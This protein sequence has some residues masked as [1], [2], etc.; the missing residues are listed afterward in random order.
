MVHP[1]APLPGRGRQVSARLPSCKGRDDAPIA[2]KR[3]RSDVMLA[4]SRDDHRPTPPGAFRRRGAGTLVQERTTNTKEG[5]SV[6][7]LRRL[8]L[9]LAS[10]GL[11]LPTAA[12]AQGFTMDEAKRA[13][14]H[15]AE[16]FV[17]GYDARHPE[18]EPAPMGSRHV[19]A[20]HGPARVPGRLLADAHERQRLLAHGRQKPR[21]PHIRVPART[22]GMPA[23]RT[24]RRRLKRLRRR[25]DHAPAVGAHP[26]C[27]TR[28]GCSRRCGS[29]ADGDRR[30]RAVVCD[31]K[32]RARRRERRCVRRLSHGRVHK[33][34]RRA[35]CG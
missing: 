31:C 26:R 28:G 2:A 11:A 4:H 32:S 3:G 24:G 13:A 17:Q 10:V 7:E 25:E 6:R 16:G 5:N 35:A 27:K 18:E 23:R 15:Y 8:A 9:A 12:Q 34:S 20:A 19:R 14:T 29:W 1:S 33:P 22:P 21:A 30:R